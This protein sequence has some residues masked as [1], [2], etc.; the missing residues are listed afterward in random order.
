MIDIHCHILPGVDDGSKDLEESLEMAKIAQSEGI[1][2]I[3]NTSHYRP[4]FDFEK[5]EILL[6]KLNNFNNFLKENNI[7]IEVF[8]GNELYYGDDLLE[9]IDKKEFYTLNNSRYLLIEF[10]PMRVPKKFM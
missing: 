1:N 5:G 4:D 9:Y 10:S 7:D 8:I 3:I 6:E 2:K